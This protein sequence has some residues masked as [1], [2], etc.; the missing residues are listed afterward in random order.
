MFRDYIIA[1]VRTYVPSGVGAL[2]SW[3]ALRGV[4][5][6]TDTQLLMVTGG[7]ALATAGYY[8]AASALQKKWPATGRYLLGSSKAPTYSTNSGGG[9]GDKAANNDPTGDA[10]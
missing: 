10:Q 5:V 4:E 7:T 3:L 9:A 1:Q 2:I 6:D 8:T